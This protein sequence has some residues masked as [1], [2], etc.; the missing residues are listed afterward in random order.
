MG[1]P[2]GSPSGRGRPAQGRRG[3]RLHL[4]APPQ[5]LGGWRRQEGR[6]EAARVLPL[7]QVGFRVGPHLGRR[8]LG[9]VRPPPRAY[10]RRGGASPLQHISSCA[11]L[12]FHL[13]VVP[14]CLGAIAS[15]SPLSHRCVRDL[16]PNSIRL[17]PGTP[18]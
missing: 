17:D 5:T 12:L 15:T 8:H 11:S 2:G 14:P 7:P 6:G 16:P 18:R 4:C 13:A 10:I 9:E 1:R 3:R